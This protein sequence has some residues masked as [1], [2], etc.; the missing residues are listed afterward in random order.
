[1]K[2]HYH[3]I[4]KLEDNGTYVGWVEEMPGALTHARSLQECRR[5]LRDAL[6]LMI[7]T[8]RHEARLALSPTCLQEPIEIDLS[9]SHPLDA[10]YAAMSTGVH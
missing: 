5:K 2:Q 1:M 6:Q 7:D 10:D 3:S 4:I 9:D 8:H